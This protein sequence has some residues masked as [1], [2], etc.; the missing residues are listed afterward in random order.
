MS[1]NMEPLYDD[2]GEEE[3]PLS[4][5]PWDDEF[6]DAVDAS[7][8]RAV[9]EAMSPLEER[10]S[11]QIAQACDRLAGSIPA[12]SPTMPSVTSLPDSQPPPANRPARWE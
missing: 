5:L 8:H 3:D 9:A 1:H 7:I 11:R 12:A 2:Q 6:Y 4:G 10:L